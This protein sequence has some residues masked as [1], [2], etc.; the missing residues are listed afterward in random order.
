MLFGAG[1][2][3]EEA[4]D[5]LSVL[6]ERHRVRAVADNDASM[7][8]RELLGVPIVGPSKLKEFSRSRGHCYV[9]FGER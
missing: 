3:S 4:L 8:G 7:W 1:K 5:Y 6:G 9:N 2:G